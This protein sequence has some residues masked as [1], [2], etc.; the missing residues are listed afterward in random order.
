MEP[1]DHDPTSD[2][3]NPLAGCVVAV[4]AAVVFFT[5]IVGLVMAWNYLLK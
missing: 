3:G 5:C 1:H 4:L 2:H